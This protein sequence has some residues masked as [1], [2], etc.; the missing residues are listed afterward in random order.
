ML[1][2]IWK[3]GIKGRDCSRSLC[4]VEDIK[5]G[6]KFTEANIRSIRPGFGMH[7]KFYN[8]MLGKK[9]KTN[10]TKGDKLS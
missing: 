2:K 3:K 1:I 10:F 8:K 9:S 4:V 6:E 7:P 5:I